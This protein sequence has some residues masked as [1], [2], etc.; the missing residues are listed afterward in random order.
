MHLAVQHNQALLRAVSV[1]RVPRATWERWVWPGVESREGG[2]TS[3]QKLTTRN[4]IKFPR[5]H[6]LWMDRPLADKDPDWPQSRLIVALALP[7]ATATSWRRCGVGV[8]SLL[9]SPLCNGVG[10]II[11]VSSAG[12]PLVEVADGL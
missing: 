12:S 2:S 9:H 4:D 7:F 11:A 8:N 10:K 3:T 1:H 6:L 5:I